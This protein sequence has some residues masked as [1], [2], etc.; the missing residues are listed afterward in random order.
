MRPRFLSQVNISQPFTSA[1]R[2]GLSPDQIKQ[3]IIALLD[4]YVSDKE[5]LSER[6]VDLFSIDAVSVG[7]LSAHPEWKLLFDFAVVVRREAMA[8][9]EQEAAAIMAYFQAPIQATQ[10]KFALQ[11]VFEQVK[12]NLTLDE[13]AFELFR[14]IGSLIEST[15]QP[16]LKEFYCLASLRE[17]LP[18]VPATTLLEDFGKVV[19]ELEKLIPLPGLV[20]PDPW[21]LR[22]NQWRN[23]AQHHTYKINGGQIVAEY[24]KSSPPNKILLMRDE[25]MD[26]A[27]EVGARLAILK[28]SRFLSVVNNLDL[29]R[30][31]LAATEDDVSVICLMLTSSFATQGFTVVG[32]DHLEDSITV[33]LIDSAP[34]VGDKRYI[35]CSQFL[36]PIAS[37]FPGKAVEVQL[38]TSD[39]RPQW[40]FN[41]TA[42]QLERVLLDN[43]PYLALSNVL[44]W[45]KALE[46]ARDNGVDVLS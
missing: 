27:R 37:H 17:G 16:F 19:V 30:P 26:V 23:I 35:H 31:F 10:S 21:G 3:D 41:L 39:G 4:P 32:F 46:I 11:V 36:L 28:S 43:D 25:L 42:E 18:V 6:A 40:A 44:D 33:R 29:L 2:D 45:R 24:G 15:I 1:L 9:D 38:Q 8:I 14:N 22:L 13:Y 5:L 7:R 34:H 20:A 12:E